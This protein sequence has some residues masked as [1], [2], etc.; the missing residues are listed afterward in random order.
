[1]LSVD[2]P[3]EVEHE[4]VSRQIVEQL[5]AYVEKQRQPQQIREIVPVALEESQGIGETDSSGGGTS[6]SGDQGGDELDHWVTYRIRFA[7]EPSIFVNGTNPLLLLAE[8]RGMGEC[9]VIP[10]PRHIPRLT[11]MDSQ[12]CY[13][14]WDVFLTTRKSLNAV[15]DVFAIEGSLPDIEQVVVINTQD[16]P[17]GFLV[18]TVISDLQTVI[19]NLGRLYHD[20]EG[21]SGATILGD[22]SVALILDVSRLAR[23]VTAH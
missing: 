8:L 4:T 1:M 20:L 3:S 15:R 14:W 17:V 19:K 11:K 5:H 16:G 23:L 7:P 21:I 10:N 9:T 12:Q 13:V 18:D 22:G 6:T 2:D